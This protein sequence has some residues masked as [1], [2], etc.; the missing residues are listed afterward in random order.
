M[1]VMSFP[2]PIKKSRTKRA[3]FQVVFPPYRR[4]LQKKYQRPPKETALNSPP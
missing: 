3:D 2:C 1:D 4:L